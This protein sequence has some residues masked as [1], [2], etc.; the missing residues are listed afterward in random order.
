MLIFQVTSPSAPVE[1]TD[2]LEYCEQQ[3]EL[4]MNKWRQN[5]STCVENMDFDYAGTPIRNSPDTQR[6]E[7]SAFGE[8]VAI[9]LRK[10]PHSYAKNK[11][12]NLITNSLFQ[13]DIECAENECEETEMVFV[14]TLDEDR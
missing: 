13:V 3:N 4:R 6:D 7:Y 8:M 5:I 1:T 12:M 14:K 2:A 10:M 11:A 9:K